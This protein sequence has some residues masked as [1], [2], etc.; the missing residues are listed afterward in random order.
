MMLSERDLEARLRRDAAVVRREAQ[1]DA[2]F[3]YRIMARVTAT[4]APVPAQRSW[5]L[6]GQLALAAGF[7]VVALALGFAFSRLNQLRPAYRNLGAPPLTE[8]AMAADP[9]HKQLVVFGGGPAV[10]TPTADTWTWDGTS[11]ARHRQA[12]GP[13]A[14]AFAAMAYDQARGEVLMFGGGLDRPLN[15]TWTWNGSTWRQAHP[16]LSPPATNGATMVYDASLQEMVLVDQGETWTWDGSSWHKSVP[17][18]G[19]GGPIAYDPLS[20]TVV[21]LVPSRSSAQPPATETWT[22]DGSA[23][24]QVKSADLPVAWSPAHL[25]QD[26]LTGSLMGVDGLRRTWSWDG[27]RWTTLSTNKPSALGAM[28]Y[29]PTRR[30]VAMFGGSTTDGGAAVSDLSVWDGRAWTLLIGGQA[31]KPPAQVAGGQTTIGFSL[32][33]GN[34]NSR[35]IIKRSISQSP[36][37]NELYETVDEGRTWQKRLQFTGVYD[38]MS[39]DQAGRNGVLWAVDLE[40]GGCPAANGPVTDCAHV[41]TRG[42]IIYVTTDGG[43]HWTARPITPWPAQLVDFHG[44]EG[45]VRS[46]LGGGGSAPLYHTSDG[47]ANWAQV[48]VVPDGSSQLAFGVGETYLEFKNSSTGWFATRRAAQPGD[49]GLLLTRDGGRTW[50]PQALAAPA[51]VNLGDLVAGYP[52]ILDGGQ[53]LLPV[54]AGNR[55]FLYMSSDGGLSWTDP[56]PL[57]INGADPTGEEFQGFCLDVTHCWFGIGS[58][59]ART[60]DGGKSWQAFTSPTLLEMRFTDANSGWAVGVTGANNTNT[61]LRTMDGGNHW[62]QVQVP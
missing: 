31:T 32:G 57:K 27:T 9:A 47:G 55:R 43:Q 20:R 42:L 39:F 28:T 49:S 36:T 62:I 5:R 56:Q 46:S 4:I 11:W 53:A 1:P 8:M 34:G 40:A 35:W 14:R 17:A 58:G 6:P 60:S 10:G 25:A 44:L 38:G 22:F 50:E 41:P 30:L 2:G 26:P 59:L 29:D 7:L 33:A 24:A 16:A 3:H 61:V 13:P 23:W 51:G 54:F 37:V 21:M 15:D 12:G 45:W 18:P 52:W 48:G 19:K